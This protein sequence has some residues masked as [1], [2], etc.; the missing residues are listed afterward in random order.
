MVK[1]RATHEAINIGKTSAM[2][3]LGLVVGCMSSPLWP[4]ELTHLRQAIREFGLGFQYAHDIEDIQALAGRVRAAAVQDGRLR[5][6][7]GQLHP[8]RHPSVGGSRGGHQAR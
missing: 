6:R 7:V 2:M 1:D 8:A 5:H 3:E 4:V